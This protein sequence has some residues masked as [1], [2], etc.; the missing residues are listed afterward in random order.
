MPIALIDI[1]G[2]LTASNEVDAIA[3]NGV[4]PTARRLDRQRLAGA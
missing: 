1:D 3:I 2:T 4:A